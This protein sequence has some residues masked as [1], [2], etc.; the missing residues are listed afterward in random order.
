[1][2][3]LHDTEGWIKPKWLELQQ[4]RFRPKTGKIQTQR[5]AMD[6]NRSPEDVV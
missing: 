3:F 6:K 1:L 4:E 2:I 5:I